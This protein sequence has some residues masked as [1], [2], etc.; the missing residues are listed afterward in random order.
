MPGAGPRALCLGVL[1]ALTQSAFAHPLYLSGTIGSAPVLLM[2]ERNDE[3]L[4]GWYL[5]LRQGKQIRLEGKVAADG[6][7]TLD[8]FGRAASQKTGQFDGRI[9]S[10]Q[11][12]GTW[13]KPEQQAMLPLRLTESADTL[14]GLSGR[15]TCATKKLDREFGYTYRHTLTLQ[16]SHGA[17]KAFDVKRGETGTHGEDQACVIA[18]SDMSQEKSDAGILLRTHG[19]SAAETG[20]RCTIRLIGAGDYLYVQMGDWTESGNDC[21]GDDAAMYCSPRSFWA[22]MIVNRKTRACVSVE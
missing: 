15:F 12:T 2:I 5:Y 8:E 19:S 11:W 9:A 1:L 17:V 4:S 7:F 22:D 6:A 21:R 14:A 16:V 3:A 10:G 20:P 18:L 13:R